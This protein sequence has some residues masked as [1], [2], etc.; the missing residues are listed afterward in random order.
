MTYTDYPEADI[1]TH[2]WVGKTNKIIGS[3]LLVWSRLE[4][5]IS[6]TNQEAL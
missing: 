2:L 6:G 3:V 4:M 5:Q 1:K